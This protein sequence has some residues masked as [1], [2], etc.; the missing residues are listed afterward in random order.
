MD[1]E[2]MGS[3]DTA[4]CPPWPV[5]G[6]WSV[7]A[8]LSYDEVSWV[9]CHDPKTE[10]NLRNNMLLSVSAQMNG[11]RDQNIREDNSKK[12]TKIEKRTSKV[13]G[14]TVSKAE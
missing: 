10:R 5:G 13:R 6:G 1:S 14:L 11:W 9:R 7:R 12:D 8:F 4:N 3:E 2:S